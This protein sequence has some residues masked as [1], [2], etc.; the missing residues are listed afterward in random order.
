[1]VVE[2]TLQAAGDGR[3]ARRLDSRGNLMSERPFV[4]PVSVADARAWVT[5]AVDDMYLILRA[6][7]VP[8]VIFAGHLPPGRLALREI[9][10][11][12]AY[13]KARGAQSMIA[14]A[15]GRIIQHYFKT[16]A[17]SIL[18][19]VYPDQVKHRFLLPPE[20]FERWTVKFSRPRIPAPAPALPDPVSP[21]VQPPQPSDSKPATGLPGAKV[22]PKPAAHPDFRLFGRKE[23]RRLILQALLGEFRIPARSQRRH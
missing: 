23:R 14:R 9:L 22:P 6:Q 20:V 10:S 18:Q 21:H 5:G 12:I 17:V 4:I 13:W 3:R 8:E 16:G 15:E 11:Q 7:L 2:E 1:M 19:E